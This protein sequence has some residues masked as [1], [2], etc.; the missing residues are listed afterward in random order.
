MLPFFSQLFD[1]SS[2]ADNLDLL[3][4]DN[5]PN[6]VANNRLDAIN[7]NAN[8]DLFMEQEE[9]IDRKRKEVKKT[10]EVAGVLASDRLALHRTLQFIEKRWREGA[11]PE[12]AFSE[13]ETFRG[14]EFDK[15]INDHGKQKSIEDGVKTLDPTPQAARRVLVDGLPVKGKGRTPPPPRRRPR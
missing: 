8:H 10:R 11:T 5:T 14:Q 6:M 4:T 1:T 9:E 7:R 3:Q 12:Q 2:S 13:A 15:I